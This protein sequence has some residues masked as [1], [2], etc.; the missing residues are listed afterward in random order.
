MTA[1][2]SG[3]SSNTRPI[4]IGFFYG[5]VAAVI[6]GGFIPVSRQGVSLGLEAVD[7]A[8]LRYVTSGLLMLPLLLRQLHTGRLSALGWAKPLILAALAGPLFIIVGASGYHF[9]P[10]ANAAVIQLGVLTLV[11]V[12]LASFLF[13]EHLGWVRL[14]GLALLV[15]GLAIIS[16]PSL[17]TASSHAWVGDLLF[18]GAGGMFAGF[19]ILVR[20]WQI[21][22]WVATSVVSVLSAAIYAPLYIMFRGMGRI[23]AVP[24]PAVAEQVFVQGLLS[25]VVAL[26]AFAQ[27]VHHLGPGRAALFPALA[28]AVA[29]LIGIP[30]LG[31]IPTS[32]QWAGLGVATFGL[33][34]SLRRPQSP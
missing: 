26:F 3:R 1:N 24:L 21:Q 11:S 22:S 13:G 15:A 16:G 20:R 5:L 30:L 31:E 19:T 28:P 7:I 29:I 34:V 8:F 14:V 27:A 33:F 10:A 6:W 12:A 23:L 17:F 32:L 18:A 2:K 9:A 4:N 25:G